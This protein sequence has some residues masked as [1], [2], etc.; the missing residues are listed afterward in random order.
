M[1]NRVM[2]FCAEE[3]WHP[4]GEADWQDKTGTKSIELDDDR[5]VFYAITIIEREVEI[6]GMADNWKDAAKVFLKTHEII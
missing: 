1:R 5:T 6:V 2:T 3:Q 4:V